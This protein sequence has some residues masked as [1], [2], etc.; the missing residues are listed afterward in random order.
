MVGIVVGRVESCPLLTL[1]AVENKFRMLVEARNLRYGG[2]SCGKM[3]KVLLR[4]TR[5]FY[6]EGKKGRQGDFD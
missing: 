3:Y 5:N 2:D 6:I 1:L 4:L